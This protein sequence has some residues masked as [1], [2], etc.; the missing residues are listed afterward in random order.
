MCA[1]IHTFRN[2]FHRYYIIFIYIYINIYNTYNCIKIDP[3][4][5]VEYTFCEGSIKITR[6]INTHILLKKQPWIFD[7]FL[8]KIISILLFSPVIKI[9]H[10]LR[11]E[12]LKVQ[13]KRG[14]EIQFL[15]SKLTILIYFFTCK[16]NTFSEC[17]AK[18]FLHMFQFAV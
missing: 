15:Y 2:V 12:M 5:M 3:F 14:K 10:V 8:K 4:L 17:I 13:K 7:H 1:H 9:T 11:R 18:L 16:N 6:Y